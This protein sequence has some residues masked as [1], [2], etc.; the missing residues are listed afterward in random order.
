LGGG[1]NEAYDFVGASASVILNGHHTSHY[2][3]QLAK[4][5]PMRILVVTSWNEI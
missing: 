4:N 2:D 5:G 1:G 3:E